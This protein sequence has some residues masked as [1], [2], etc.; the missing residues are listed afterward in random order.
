MTEL[1]A[2]V[3]A[4][5]TFKLSLEQ[6]SHPSKSNILVNFIYL[7]VNTSEQKLHSVDTN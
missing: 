7:K 3:S 4:H 6:Q 5:R 1:P 2:F